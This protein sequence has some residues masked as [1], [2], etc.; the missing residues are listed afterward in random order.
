MA[1]DKRDEHGLTLCLA[2]LSH[3][4]AALQNV[5]SEGAPSHVDLFY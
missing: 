3:F 4:K 1:Q 2:A 5:G